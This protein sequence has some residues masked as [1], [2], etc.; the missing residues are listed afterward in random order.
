MPLLSKKEVLNL[1]LYCIPL[2]QLKKLA[3]QFKIDNK[4]SASDL[5]KRII[6]INPDENKIDLFIKE[7]YKSQIEERRKIISDE[8]LKSELLK[9]K[10]FSWGTVQGQLDQKIQLE[11]VRKIVK[12]D[13][14]LNS[15]K[16]KLHNDV[17]HYVICTWF[18]HWTTVLIE[19]HIGNHPRVI[20]TIKKIKGVD[21]FFDGQPFDLKI[22]NLP[23]NYNAI[24]AVKEPQK[25]AI[26]LYENQGAQ[27]FGYDNRLFIILLDKENPE[28]SW[29]LKRD[30][31]LIY[32][33]ID[34]FLDNEKITKKDEIVFKFQK[35][36]YTT[37]TKI[38]IITR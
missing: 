5:I 36:T 30:F 33:K 35:K 16:L 6:L 34:K 2:E 15:V 12:Y 20:P 13:D 28:N 17:T 7:I 10:D 22:T 1:K 38:L 3:M 26:W 37:A 19:E 11:Y 9:V 14:L 4:G 21:I 31:N 18:N 25:L 29:Q 23:K 27:R 8:A 32:N 24:E